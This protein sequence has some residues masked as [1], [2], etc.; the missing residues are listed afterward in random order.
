MAPC[1]RGLDSRGN[2]AWHGQILASPPQLGKKT[3]ELWARCASTPFTRST[4]L[5][6]TVMLMMA[7]RWG[8]TYPTGSLRHAP[9]IEDEGPDQTA[10][11]VLREINRRS[12]SAPPSP[13]L[14]AHLSPVL[15]NPLLG[16]DLPR[17]AW[18]WYPDM[19]PPQAKK[20]EHLSSYNWNSFGLRYGK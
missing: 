5:L 6:L 1:Q 9:Y 15:T 4:M 17:R 10:M 14:S 16:V 8:E 2:R 13:L 20:R 19:P 3:D 7:V 11:T 18:W 12:M